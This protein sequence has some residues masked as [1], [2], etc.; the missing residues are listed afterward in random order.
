MSQRGDGTPPWKEHAVD[1]EDLEAR[2]DQA[3]RRA[4]LWGINERLRK[5]RLEEV[6]E[7]EAELAEA[8]AQMAGRGRRRR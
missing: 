3:R 4:D 8:E 2:L 5:R 1:I 6:A 7:L